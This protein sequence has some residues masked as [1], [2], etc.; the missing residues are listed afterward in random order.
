VAEAMNVLPL[1]AIDLY[2]DSQTSTRKNTLYF[3]IFQ[4]FE[5]VMT[6]M[7][8]LMLS[9][10]IPYVSSEF[11]DCCAS[12][13]RRAEISALILQRDRLKNELVWDLTDIFCIFY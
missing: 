5:E 3:P 4:V 7:A 11:R 13:K 8:N 9:G 2:A 1:L 10:T 6:S 12:E